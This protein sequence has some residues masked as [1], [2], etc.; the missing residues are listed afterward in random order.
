MPLGDWRRWRELEG[1]PLGRLGSVA[2][3]VLPLWISPTLPYFAV[4][5]LHGDL[6]GPRLTDVRNA[7]EPV[8]S[9]RGSDYP[10]FAPA[11]GAC[12]TAIP[13]AEPQA[14]RRICFHSRTGR[15]HGVA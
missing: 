3:G 8:G 10:R 13:G 4:D 7:G 14:G 2:P 6:L 9:L 11:A 5:R 15:G 1:S 12:A